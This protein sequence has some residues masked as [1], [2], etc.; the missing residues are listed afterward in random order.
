MCHLVGD[1]AILS[2]DVSN[3]AINREGTRKSSFSAESAS[4]M[5]N[6]MGP[7][8]KKAKRIRLWN[9]DGPYCQMCGRR[10]TSIHDPNLTIDHII[11]MFQ[12][13]GNEYSNLRLACWKCNFGR[14]H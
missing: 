2:I 1:L 8:A 6:R 11:P 4:E 3:V 12:G 13:G 14:H 10:F 9:E 7:R 5:V